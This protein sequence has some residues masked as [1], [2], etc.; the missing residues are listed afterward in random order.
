MMIMWLSIV[1]IVV[2]SI[3]I[4]SYSNYQKQKLIEDR[5]T[6]NLALA[7]QIL[8]ARPDITIEDIQRLIGMSGGTLNLSDQNAQNNQWNKE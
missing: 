3:A 4:P 2:V 7:Y 1:A 8:Q 6:N 5:K